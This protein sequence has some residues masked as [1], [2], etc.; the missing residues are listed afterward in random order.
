MRTL[1]FSLCQQAHQSTLLI[2]PEISAVLS[3]PHFLMFQILVTVSGTEFSL[4]VSEI[5]L[6]STTTTIST[7]PAEALFH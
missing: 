7:W 2:K 6:S 1:E 5:L 4:F 3:V